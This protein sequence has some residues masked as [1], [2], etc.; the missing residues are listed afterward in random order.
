MALRFVPKRRVYKALAP[1]GLLVFDMAGPARAPSYNRERTF[2]E[3][4]D[5]AVMM[6]AEVDTGSNLLT[7]RITSFRKLG[8]LYRRD[9]E[10]HQLQLVDPLE[11]VES[12][13]RIGFSVQTIDCYGSLPLPRGLVGFVEKKPTSVVNAQQVV[14][15]DALPR[16]SE[17]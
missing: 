10:L 9:C 3:G 14:P 6:E 12:L 13:Q 11:I 17:L 2:A 16:A 5:W 8:D 1:G 15:A 4:P 7:R